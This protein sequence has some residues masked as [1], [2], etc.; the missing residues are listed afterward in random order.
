MRA[1]LVLALLLASCTSAPPAPP[2][3]APPEED[4]IEVLILR[5]RAHREAGR[6]VEAEQD[7]EAARKIFDRA[8][9][10]YYNDGVR[11]L[12]QGRRPEADRYFGY[13]LELDPDH[14]R[15]RL[16]MARAYM[17]R[18]RYADAAREYDRLIR[19]Q[20]RD[21]GLYYHRGNARLLAG[22]GEE[23]LADF[24]LAVEL[25]P[26]DATY[27][28]ARAVARHRVRGDLMLARLDFDTALRLDEVCYHAWY[29]RG[30]LRQDVQDYEGA[31]KDLRRAMSIRSSPEGAIALG[32]L[33]QARGD[34]AAA[35]DVLR[36]AIG[37]YP[38]P[39]TQRMLNAALER[40]L[41]ENP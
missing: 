4:P 11:A 10:G 16:A 14:Q 7:L 30:L 38:D 39:E 37:I 35:E 8:A 22:M 32:R 15:A 5:S 17:E 23:A 31:E 19:V 9:D 6:R 18:R 27:L 21:A 12:A 28:A 29:G 1:L 25:V 41:K 26:T 24:T 3:A 13:A 2:P 36:K 33:L 40:L 34:R 20:P